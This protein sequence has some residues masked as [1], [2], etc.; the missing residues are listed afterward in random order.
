MTCILS[1]FILDYKIPKEVL[2]DLVYTLLF[3]TQQL[4]QFSM[5]CSQT[6]PPDTPP[7]EPT[8][9]MTHEETDNVPLSIAHA[10]TAH[11]SL[12]KIPTCL[13]FQNAPLN[14]VTFLETMTQDSCGPPK[15]LN[16]TIFFCN[17]FFFFFNQNMVSSYFRLK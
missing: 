5:A 13:L 9:S 14:S 8:L 12:K 10:Q 16:V 3:I 2:P 1:L 6:E 4:S 17:S 7:V 15:Q 11:I